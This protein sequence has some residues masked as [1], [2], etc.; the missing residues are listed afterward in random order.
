MSSGEKLFVETSSM[1]ALA[2]TVMLYMEVK[3]MDKEIARIRERMLND[4]TAR[5]RGQTD[6][7]RD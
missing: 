1:S 7:N 6:L 4:L 3:K 2:G 5:A